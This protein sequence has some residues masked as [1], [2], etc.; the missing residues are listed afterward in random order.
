[1][2]VL[3][4]F[5]VLLLRA[6]M[7]SSKIPTLVKTFFDEEKPQCETYFHNNKKEIVFERQH[8]YGIKSSFLFSIRG[9]TRIFDG[10]VQNLLDRRKIS[11]FDLILVQR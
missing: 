5:V 3:S 2:L 6:K 4:V 11:I 1:M 7:R 8:K 9:V 10:W